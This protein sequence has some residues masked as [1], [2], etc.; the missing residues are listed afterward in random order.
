M[1]EL[2]TRETEQIRTPSGEAFWPFRA[3][4]LANPA[5]K[6]RG[7][8]IIPWKERMWI[9]KEE[10]RTIYEVVGYQIASA[11]GLPI[12]PWLA[13]ERAGQLQIGAGML[14]ELLPN[15]AGPYDLFHPPALGSE[16]EG[17]LARAMA[18]C[19]FKRAE[20]EWPEWLWSEDNTNLR[21]IDLDG[22]CPSLSLTRPQIKIHCYREN[23]RSAYAEMRALSAAHE[24][25][26]AFDEE[27]DRLLELDFAR[28]VDLSGHPKVAILTTTILRGLRI[29]QREVIMLKQSGCPSPS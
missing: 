2:T 19:V 8:P 24:I 29:R 12:Q 10:R 13:F 16:T 26:R 22:I 27:L 17:V 5:F 23:T 14:I 21:L 18:M 1:I 3:E 20:G 6:I 4:T 15:A 7:L 28:V 25:S 9:C 11:M